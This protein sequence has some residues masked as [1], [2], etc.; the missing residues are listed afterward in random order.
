M[1]DE[2]LLQDFLLAI[3]VLII[4][5]GIM[6]VVDDAPAAMQYDPPCSLEHQLNII[7]AL[8]CVQPGQESK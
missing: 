7:E 4:G 2:K 3:T 5:F 8:R 1:D 6:V